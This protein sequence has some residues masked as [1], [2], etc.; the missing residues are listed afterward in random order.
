VTLEAANHGEL[1]QALKR[2][3]PDTVRKIYLARYCGPAA[4]AGLP[5]ALA[6]M[7]FDAAVNHGV[8]AALRML[9]EA[10]GT[11]IDGEIGPQT[12]AAVAAKPLHEVIRS[13]A[14]IRRARY[15]V[16]PHFWRFG[17]GWLNRTAKTEERALAL[18]ED[19]TSSSTRKK[20]PSPMQNGTTTLPGGK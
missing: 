15:R 2:I 3:A 16:L 4:C 17:H 9:Q 10:V 18:L 14:E 19:A 20:G 11:E 1:K 7:Q 13:Y 5:P 8:G 6:F 12:R